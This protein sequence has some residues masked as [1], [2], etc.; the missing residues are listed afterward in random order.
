MGGQMELD[1]D[2]DRPPVR[3]SVPQAW[4]LAGAQA[5]AGAMMA[6]AARSRTGLGQQVD[7]S[8]QESVVW[9]LMIAAQTWDITRVNPR[10]GG[11]TREVRRP[12]GVVLRQRVVW[13]CR[14]GF[15][16]WALSGGS[17]AGAVASMRGLVGWLEEEGCA[18]ELGAIDWG[19][20]SPAALDQE[21]Y[22]RLTAPVARFFLS[23]TKRE[24]FEGAVARSIQLA[25]A[26]TLADLPQSPQLA[27]RDYFV[28]VPHP[29][30]GLTLQFPGAPVR[31]SKTPWRIAG[32]AP[33]L[34]EHN[35]QVYCD[36]L[37]LGREELAQLAMEGVI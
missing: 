18:G 10:R 26:N 2:A 4:G 1:G 30:L 7:V 9:T 17:Q 23:K 6:H 16:Y 5:A 27:A 35:Q 32:P 11:S 33:A 8:A 28:A 20:Q 22:D 31:L 25:P 12:N 29:R 37:G 19:A 13:P 36:L 34:G 3:V 14:D 15:I 21:R 24:L